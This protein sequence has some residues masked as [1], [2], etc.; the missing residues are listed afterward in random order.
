MKKFQVEEDFF[1]FD[2]RLSE[3]NSSKL[4][5]SIIYFNRIISINDYTF[6]GTQYSSFTEVK[7]ACNLKKALRNN[8]MH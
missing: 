3:T 8:T 7:F 2:H 1:L 6:S 5:Y 4:K